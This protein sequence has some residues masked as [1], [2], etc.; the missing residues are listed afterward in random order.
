MQRMSSLQGCLPRMRLMMELG[1]GLRP[2]LRPSW[3]QTRK[4]FSQ[5]M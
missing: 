1:L 4:M 3:S 2:A 5:D